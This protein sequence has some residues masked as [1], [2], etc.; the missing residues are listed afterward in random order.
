MRRLC[1]AQTADGLGARGDRLMA[2]KEGF[3]VLFL[4]HFIIEVHL[5]MRLLDIRG[6][7]DSFRLTGSILCTCTRGAA[8][9]LS[10]RISL[11]YSDCMGC[12]VRKLLPVQI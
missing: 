9:T 4:E 5:I 11:L 12:C 8:E 3:C 7:H 6:Q 2:I 1:V 10:F